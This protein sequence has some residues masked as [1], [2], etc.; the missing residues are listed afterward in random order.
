MDWPQWVSAACDA[1]L[2]IVLAGAVISIHNKL[3][4]IARK[5]GVRFEHPMGTEVASESHRD[6]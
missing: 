4:A 2:V 6:H 5:L 1:C 3:N